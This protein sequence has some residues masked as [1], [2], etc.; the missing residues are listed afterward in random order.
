MRKSTIQ[1]TLPEIEIVTGNSTRNS[2]SENS[3]QS[4]QVEF[5]ARNTRDIVA[6]LNNT[7]EQCSRR[8]DGASAADDVV[9]IDLTNDDVLEDESIQTSSRML[10]TY[11]CEGSGSEPN[12]QTDS[13]ESDQSCLVYSSD[14]LD[15]DI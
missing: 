11:V 5:V 10:L 6:Q 2:T 9:E 3:P 12:V 1:K 15:P 13:S 4:K 8:T 14:S 7:A